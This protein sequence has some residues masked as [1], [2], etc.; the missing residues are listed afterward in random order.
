[1]AKK[2][3]PTRTESEKTNNN[4]MR[5]VIME[6]LVLNCGGT[7]EKLDRSVKLLSLLSGKKV[8]E[9]VS[10]KRIPT[11][12][13]RPGLKT[14]CFVT[15]RGDEKEALLKRLFGAVGNKIKK[16]QIANNHFSF[17]IKEYLEIPDMEYQ[18]DIGVIG[19]DVTIVFRRAGKRTG[20]KKIKSGKVP[21]KQDVTPEE[22]ADY[23]RTKLNIEVEE[24]GKKSEED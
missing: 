13:V 10:Q 22:I 15:L 4:V 19:L 1:M 7:A 11:F 21:K 17:G 9:I 16:K 24:A 5:K 14:G 18:R 23:L 12:G 6:K 20:M 3:T 2:V 8:K